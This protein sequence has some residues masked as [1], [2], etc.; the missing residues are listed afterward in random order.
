MNNIA[1]A[2]KPKVDNALRNA[3]GVQAPDESVAHLNLL[4]YG[5]PGAGKTWLAGTAMDHADTSP[6]LFLDVEGGVTT[7]RKRK[8]LDVIQIRSIE[9]IVKV[10]D[11][12]A[13]RNGGG[14]STVVID[15][16]SELQ[17]LDMRTVMLDEFNR[18]KNPENID[19]DVPTQKAWGKSL[20]RL[21][22]IIRG[23]RDLPVH[24]IMTT[25]MNT[26]TD[27]QS[28][29]TTYHPALPGK[30]RSEAPG[31]FDVVGMLRVKE[32]QNGAVR[33]RVLQVT[34]TSKVIG[35]DRTDSLGI[36]DGK[37]TGVIYEPTIPDMWHT[38]T[39]KSNGK[40]G[41]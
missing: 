16:I 6:V 2:T 23:Y 20:E 35:K 21:R 8:N 26:T 32:E 27:E 29:V 1:T 33:R 15:S 19:K 3:L 10:H 22:R 9:Q 31:F 12:L 24:T 40:V 11:E 5:E 18:A 39:A 25:L 7:L 4:I 30:M 37:H 41:N 34:A 36:V 38:I 28:N 13:N 17:K 14:Y